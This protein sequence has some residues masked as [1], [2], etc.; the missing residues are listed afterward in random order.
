MN[1]TYSCFEKNIILYIYTVNIDDSKC[2][3]RQTSQYLLETHSV[4]GPRPKQFK[5][6]RRQLV[7]L[8]SSMTRYGGFLSHRI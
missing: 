8:A 7:G 1:H 2:Q 3:T 5:S 4:A 6:T